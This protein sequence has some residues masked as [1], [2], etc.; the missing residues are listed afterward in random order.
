MIM[1]M[2]FEMSKQK[3]KTRSA[4]G[5]E[6]EIWKLKKNCFNQF[7]FGDQL[8]DTHRDQSSSF[9]TTKKNYHKKDSEQQQQQQ[10]IDYR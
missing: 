10:T 9:S 6:F 1:I 7:F 5:D 4:D 8:T 2:N 3:N